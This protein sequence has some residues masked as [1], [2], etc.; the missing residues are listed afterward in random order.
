MPETQSEAKYELLG[1]ERAAFPAALSPLEVER[2]HSDKT[3]RVRNSPVYHEGKRQTLKAAQQRW[4]SVNPP[5]Y[6]PKGSGASTGWENK[7]I[8]DTLR[9]F[10]GVGDT[11]LQGRYFGLAARPPPRR[12]SFD[13]MPRPEKRVILPGPHVLQTFHRL[14][15]HIQRIFPIKLKPTIREPPYPRPPRHET[16][17]EKLLW[18]HPVPLTNRLIRVA[19]EMVW[20]RLE[21]SRPVVRGDNSE[22]AKC[23]YDEMKAW[24][25][26]EDVG[27]SPKG[28]KRLPGEE[29]PDRPEKWGLTTPDEERWLNSA[30][31]EEAIGFPS[32]RHFQDDAPKS[33]LM[34]RGGIDRLDVPWDSV[35]KEQLRED[36]EDKRWLTRNAQILRWMGRWEQ[37]QQRGRIDKNQYM[38]F[39]SPSPQ[40]LD[41]MMAWEHQ[42]A[43]EGMRWG[44]RAASDAAD[45]EDTQRQW[46]IEGD[47][48]YRYF[49][50]GKR[51]EEFRHVPGSKR[52]TN[53]RRDYMPLPG[54]RVR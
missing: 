7:G 6:L 11:V 21:W 8:V 28:R 46:I 48:I 17:D 37:M 24:E 33:E 54:E 29:S 51:R 4:S 1:E 41:W 14:P 38:D 42:L 18:A 34:S 23:S 12:S 35:K 52:M 45:M 15:P 22:W 5:I 20:N 39:F 40:E 31:I 50:D 16:K 44:M 26:G 10:A 13:S 19:Y 9:A 36:T 27:R 49:G 43:Q 32:S 3:P 2:R 30:S 25:R 47:K 53:W